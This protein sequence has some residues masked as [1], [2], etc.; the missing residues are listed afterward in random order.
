[1]YLWSLSFSTL[2][3][4]WHNLTPYLVIPLTLDIVLR[5]LPL[6]L[7][8]SPT[9]GSLESHRILT[10]FMFPTSTWSHLSGFHESLC[11]LD[12]HLP[13]YQHQHSFQKGNNILT[14]ITFTM[15]SLGRHR[16][17]HH[18]SLILLTPITFNFNKISCY[19]GSYYVTIAFG[20]Y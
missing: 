6:I 13:F 11:F 9:K 1:M 20:L 17:K 7:E 14:I 12:S 16:E 10:S 3:S 5:L 19:G 4:L 15:R 18:L 2:S 8:N